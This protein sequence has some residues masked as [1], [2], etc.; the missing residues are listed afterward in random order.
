M[1][2]IRNRLPKG[3]AKKII[4]ILDQ[5]YPVRQMERDWLALVAEVERITPAVLSEQH[6][7]RARLYS[8]YIQFAV[9][10]DRFFHATVEGRIS[11]A[12]VIRLMELKKSPSGFTPAQVHRIFS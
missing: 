4:D 11:R 12:Q 3:E 8:K 10:Y 1:E 5:E 9:N 2:G 7:E 6:R